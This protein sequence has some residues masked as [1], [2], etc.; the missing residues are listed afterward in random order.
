MVLNER[1]KLKASEICR[2]NGRNTEVVDNCNKY[3]HGHVRKQRRLQQS[4]RTGDT[5]K[6]TLVTLIKTIQTLQNLHETVCES[7]ITYGIE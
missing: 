3:V 4:A 6:C 2:M 1:I 5:H 7:K